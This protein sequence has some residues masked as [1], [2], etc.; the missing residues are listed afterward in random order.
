[1]TSTHCRYDELNV[2]QW[3]NFLSCIS[4]EYTDDYHFEY[5]LDICDSA[6]YSRWNVTVF[7]DMEFYSFI[8]WLKLETYGTRFQV[9]G[10]DM[11]P[12]Q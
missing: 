4:K 10:V 6:D 1:M 9:K 12:P 5:D 11:L 8:D 3:L 2:C 7:T